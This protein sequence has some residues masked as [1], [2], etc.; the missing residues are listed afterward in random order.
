MR[1]SGNGDDEE[2]LFMMV[3]IRVPAPA[4]PTTRRENSNTAV[5]P[6]AAKLVRKDWRKEVTFVTELS[7]VSDGLTSSPPVLLTNPSLM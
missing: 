4:Y 7:S 6:A 1:F 5:M 2:R 3:Q